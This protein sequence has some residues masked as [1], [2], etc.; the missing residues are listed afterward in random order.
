MK[1][2][3]Y[4]KCDFS[5][6]CAALTTFQLTEGLARSLCGSWAILVRPHRSSLIRRCARSLRLSRSRAVQKRLNRSR[7]DA[8]WA[9]DSGGP[10]QPCTGGVQIPHANG[11]FWGEK[12]AAHCKVPGP[13]VESS[14][15]TAEPIKM[16]FGMWTRM[17]PCKHLLDGVHIGATYRLSMCCG[18]AAS[19]QVTLTTCFYGRP[20]Q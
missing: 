18:D 15:K 12:E 6:S 13:S 17:G 8:V 9:V 16:S 10:K 14:A 7:L 2:Q 3:S 20:M 4:V 19:C 11:Q 1:G 5:Y